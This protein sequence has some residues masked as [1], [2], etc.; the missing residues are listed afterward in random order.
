[1]DNKTIPYS[2]ETRKFESFSTR[3]VDCSSS[4]SSGCGSSSGSDSSSSGSSSRSDNSSSG[5]NI[6]SNSKNSSANASASGRYVSNTTS[7]LKDHSHFA[8]EIV[9]NR[10]VLELP[11]SE[12]CSSLVSFD[13]RKGM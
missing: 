6:S 2:L 9:A 12:S 11:P 4:S 8:G 5:S 10:N 13:S 7:T 3:S 1:M